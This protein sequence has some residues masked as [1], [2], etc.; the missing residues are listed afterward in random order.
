MTRVLIV[1][2]HPLFREG[3]AGLLATIEGVE[4]AGSVGTAEAA[5]EFCAT[6]RPDVVL[7]DVNLP[8]ASG[9]AATARLTRTTPAPAVL[10]VTMVD[11]DETV[12]AALSAGARGYLLKDATPEDI[13]AALRTVVSGGAVLGAGVAGRLLTQRER[14]NDEVAVDD[15][16]PRER[17]VL[18][19]LAR[20][21]TN[22]QIARALGISLKTVQ[23]TVSRVLDKLQVA[24]RTQAALKARQGRP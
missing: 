21:R 1:D 13:H 2:D 12:L 3:L 7:M 14:R 22:A 6:D 8:G 19:L 17:E 11:D 18:D 16:T 10:M 5:L 23:N 24:D 9:V 20:G 4:V 15:L